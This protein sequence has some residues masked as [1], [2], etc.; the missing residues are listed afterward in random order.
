MKPALCFFMRVR[1]SLLLLW[2]LWA[3]C[4]SLSS[5]QVV[6]VTSTEHSVQIRL[7][8]LALNAY[9]E[10]HSSGVHARLTGLDAVR[11]PTA[12][13]SVAD[14]LAWTIAVP[15]DG[16]VSMQWHAIGKPHAFGR[17]RLSGT[18]TSIVPLLTVERA[19]K[20]AGQSVAIVRFIPWMYDG[21]LLQ[22]VDN[23]EITITFTSALAAAPPS[24]RLRLPSYV[25][26]LVNATMLSP[27]QR[28]GKAFTTGQG[29][30]DPSLWYDP[31][32]PH[33]RLTTARDGLARV[34]AN[35]VAPVQ[36][37]LIDVTTS[38]LALWYKGVEQPLAIVDANAD[39]KFNGNDTL[40]FL[41]RRSQGDTTW[42]N[43]Y[44]TVSV[45]FLSTGGS[46]RFTL[47]SPTGSN[48]RATDRLT[49]HAHV[50]LDT[51]YYH[52]GN[53]VDEDRGEYNSDWVT[54]EGFYWTFMNARSHDTLH[55]YEVITPADS[56]EMQVTAQIVSITSSKNYTPEHRTALI[57]NGHDAVITETEGK[58]FDS[59]IVKGTDVIAS[60]QS[61]FGLYAVGRPNMSDTS[62]YLSQVCLDYYRIDGD[63]KPYLY[64][65]G[66]IADVAASID[67]S[68]RFDVTGFAG[69]RVYAL[70]T[71]AQI[72]SIVSKQRVGTTIRGSVVPAT[73]RTWGPTTTVITSDA[74]IVVNDSARMWTIVSGFAAMMISGSV[75]NE[76]QTNDAT[77]FDTWLRSL[78]AAS[79]GGII[80]ARG[81]MTDVL[82]STLSSLGVQEGGK[83]VWVSTLVVGLPLQTT[84][85]SSSE[86]N[87]RAS[88]SA[89]LEHAEGRHHVAPVTVA[90]GERRTIVLQDE[91]SIE[92]ARVGIAHMRNLRA[93]NTQADAIYIAHTSN[94]Q[95][96]NRLAAHRRSYN[97]ATVTVIDVDD[98][99]DEFGAGHRSPEA[100]RAFLQQAYE[101]WPLPRP[102]TLLLIGNATFD[103]RLAI[104]SGNLRSTRPDQVPTY[105]RPSSD[106]WFGLLSGD[107]VAYPE[108]QVGRLPSLT[109]EEARNMVDKII[110][111]DTVQT[112]PWMRRLMF[113]GGGTEDEGF[114][115]MYQDLLEDPFDTG[116]TLTGPPLCIDT[117]TVC[118]SDDVSTAGY[119]IKQGIN[120]GATWMN[121]LGHGAT[122]IFDVPGWNANELNN[123]GKCGMLATYACQT[124]AY[125][126]PSATC[127]NA[128]YLIEPNN[129]FI[130]AV[131]G[132]GWTYKQT[133]ANLHYGFQD[134]MKT[135]S[136]TMGDIVYRTKTQFAVDGIQEGI[137]TAMQQCILGDPMSTIRL[138]TVVDGYLRGQDVSITD[139]T[140]DA[141][142]TVED[143]SVL[144][145]MNVQNAGTGTTTA[146]S[147][148][149]IRTYNN[150]ADTVRVIALDGLCRNTVLRCTLDI[151]D[152]VGEHGL[153]I[154]ID[155]DSL[156]LGERA[157]N[158]TL[159]LSFQVVP[160]SMLPVEP[161]AFWNVPS[162]SQTSDAV[163]R[164]LDPLPPSSDRIYQFFVTK[165]QRQ[166]TTG[167]IVARSVAS[168]ITVDGTVIDWRPSVS[169]DTVQHYV[170]ARYINGVDTSAML[171]IPFYPT[172]QPYASVV[173]TTTTP[174][175]I[176][177]SASLGTIRLE[178]GIAMLKETKDL[179]VRSSGIQ[180]SDLE[181]QRIIEVRIGLN[182]YVNNPFARGVNVVVV[183]AHDTIPRAVRR[184]DTYE[185]PAPRETGHDGFTQECIAFL[186]DSIA[187]DERAIIALADESI[188]GFETQ[189]NL[190]SLVAILKT[191]GSA[192]ADSLTRNAS[193]TMIGIR[194]RAI[195]SV[196]ERFKSAP[197]SM[198][199]IDS[200]LDFIAQTSVVASPWFGPSR[201]WH[202]FA[203]EGIGHDSASTIIEA[204]TN[205]GETVILDTI[206]NGTGAWTPTTPRTDVAYMRSVTTIPF[207]DWKSAAVRITGMTSSYEP[208]DEWMI[209]TLQIDP[210]SALRGD[211]SLLS[212]S[213]RNVY[214]SFASPTVA[215][216]ITGIGEGETEPKFEQ[217]ITLDA[218]EA[219]G[220]RSTTA[221][222]PSTILN[223]RSTFTTL[224]NP[225][226]DRTELYRFNNTASAVYRVGDDVV[227]PTIE[228]RVDG[229]VATNGMIVLREPFMEVL[230]HDNSKLAINDSTRLTV[231]INGDRIRPSNTTEFDFLPTDTAVRRY[232]IADVRSA[233]VFR[234]PLELNQNNIIVRGMDASG[235]ADTIELALYTTDRTTLRA[236]TPSPN[237][238]TYEVAFRVNLESALPSVPATIAI[239]DLSGGL[240]R[241][242][243]TTVTLGTSVVPWD[244]RGEGG[245]S[246]ASG[247]YV[248]RFATDD[249]SGSSALVGSIVLIR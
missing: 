175:D 154:T 141:Q 79:A 86:S 201:S 113:V 28:Q 161:Q 90:P 49:L 159:S 156:M 221:S 182:N 35:D 129:G 23:A 193:W 95:E 24:R 231:F 240:V 65:G 121:Y 43:L 137:N 124:G 180:T 30:V 188:S 54:A 27:E 144:I 211:T 21:T 200:T 103:A 59:V 76:I 146:L 99:L 206:P 102:H 243:T 19:G 229:I 122:E 100:V 42:F 53:A 191:Y 62:N 38:T 196:T 125:S 104:R 29:A 84:T 248:W 228:V 145:T 50:E 60:G 37:A 214:R 150:A 160:R 45:F 8:G 71:A 12:R 118:K 11:R 109:S 110:A 232:G 101:S 6:R 212:V 81:G 105:G 227:P 26:P 162:A 120:L 48:V 224:V 134:A 57:V 1:S 143:D 69:Q 166:L 217:T 203:V 78:P 179:F 142:I 7:S 4:S 58:R 171:V 5:A 244:G 237:P 80:C 149:V 14:L 72:L 234:Y 25:P 194:G 140:G 205:G 52:L 155:P 61:H 181:K 51:G 189:N 132:T 168:E 36:P 152:R 94:M 64:Q 246:L 98:V 126:T 178:D 47:T 139:R 190:D 138:D 174:A 158:N 176:V 75:I 32:R 170:H 135:G 208:A 117:I 20:F 167:S 133:V 223:G 68:T 247:I 233:V 173:N 96:A 238:F 15:D 13:G 215:C 67:S 97:K 157:A 92:S 230:L 209:N 219:N 63:V 112:A 115:S 130:G 87:G 187:G 131:G 185:Y 153:L 82:R 213:V 242:L 46:K 91:R 111:H 186:R 123:A 93:L 165:Q 56:A 66:L 207:V 74:S 77:T 114:C 18:A 41:G 172:L 235:N 85:T 210:D 220:G 163:I 107:D 216:A 2:S 106:Y 177:T 31:T 22:V 222:I 218:L 34:T 236:V 148:R 197:D 89:F 44:D 199:V 70:D 184:Y 198:V 151:A 241:T 40:Y 226:Q 108:L 16:D 73:Q 128:T 33:A 169:F 55:H 183:G 225:S 116:Y 164:V 192:Y 3:F 127:K 245:E 202:R 88:T 204:R 136:R 9:C 17:Q 39:G 147:V 119:R 83:A 195:G 249:P 10:P 239:Y